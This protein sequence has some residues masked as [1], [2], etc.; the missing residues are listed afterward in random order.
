[1]LPAPA[2]RPNFAEQIG[3]GL[4]RLR[5]RSRLDRIRRRRERLEFAHDRFT[6]GGTFAAR[7][8]VTLRIAEEEAVARATESLPDR[9]GSR[10]L[11]GTDR[12]PLALQ[13]P[14]LGDRRLPVGR[15]GERFGARAELFLL[16]KVLRPYGLALGEIG[17]APREEAIA[18][19]PE[20]LPDGLLLPSRDGANR[21]PFGLQL[22]DVLGR[23]NPSGRVGERFGAL[24]ERTLLREVRLARFGLRGEMRLALRPRLVVCRLEA[25]PQRLALRARD[26]GGLAPLLLQ[27]AH[28]ARDLL[29]VVQR[30][31]RFHF[32]AELLLDTDVRPALPV[33]D[34]AQ[35]LHLWHQ[36]ALRCFEPVDDLLVIAT[37]GQWRNRRQCGAQIAQ[38]ALA[39]FER[40][41]GPR[42][43]RLDA[44][45]ELLETLER[46]APRAAILILRRRFAR[47]HLTVRGRKTLEKSAVCGSGRGQVVPFAPGDGEPP[48]R[49]AEIGLGRGCFGL[50]HE[51]RQAR[52]APLRVAA[53]LLLFLGTPHLCG[54]VLLR[55]PAG[56]GLLF[57]SQ[58]LGLRLVRTADCGLRIADC[59]LRRFRFRRSGI[60]TPHS[61]IRNP[62]SDIRNRCSRAIVDLAHEH[63]RAF[64]DGLV[65]GARRNFVQLRAVREVVERRERRILE[66]AVQRDGENFLP[67]LEPLERGQ[68]HRFVRRVPGDRS[69]RA[70]IGDAR[71]CAGRD[72]FLR[73][74]FRNHREGLRVDNRVHGGQA[75]RLSHAF[76]R[77]ECNVAEHR[78]RLGPDPFLHV[79]ARDFRKR[80]RV[81]ELGCR[82]APHARVLVAARDFGEQLVLVDRDFLYEREPDGGI[83]VFL[84]R[85]RAEAVEQRHSQLR[86]ADCGLR[87][88]CDRRFTMSSPCV[89]ARTF[90]S[91][92]SMRP[93]RPM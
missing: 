83:G 6:R 90:L 28:L 15:I 10:L 29:G 80:P 45:G 47:R 91:I 54:R 33:G 17:V 56:G 60:R 44:C 49:N 9:F 12:L 1:M 74:R 61:G 26:V 75:L 4:R 48:S 76:E 37:R 70:R 36:R 11:D 14:D 51:L 16:H 23:L 84:T 71:D 39:G 27:I 64:G 82:R 21:L 8:L 42:R 93:S 50:D 92:A 19:D 53:R 89:E 25:A 66:L 30:L 67:I 3:R 52:A 18:G 43:E 34:V 24:G 13:P 81:H 65:L 31:Q 68:P 20:P 69:Q 79:V 86:I 46:L 88:D 62:H 73:G 22:L 5:R 59:G 2:Q 78:V 32:F 7:D 85:L 63:A 41:L 58:P 35:L 40:Q 87:I 57:D 77:L 55:E 72:R 38:G